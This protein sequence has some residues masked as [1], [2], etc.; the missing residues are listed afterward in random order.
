MTKTVACPACK[1]KA[2]LDKTNE[3]RPF[4]SQRCKDGDFIE[5]SNEENKIAGAPELEDLM[6]G[7]IDKFIR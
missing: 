1:N 7:D 5:W 4:C 3:F 2:S 6:S